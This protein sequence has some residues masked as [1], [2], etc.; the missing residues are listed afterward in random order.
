MDKA[1]NNK[2]PGNP[3]IMCDGRLFTDYHPNVTVNEKLDKKYLGHHHN[4][5]LYRQFLI[6]NGKNLM[7]QD[8]QNVEENVRCKNIHSQKYTANGLP[9]HSKCDDTSAY[10]DFVARPKN[11]M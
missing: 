2:F 4:D 9:G 6:K 3:G 8:Y 1:L 7:D 10:I 11:L 5:Y